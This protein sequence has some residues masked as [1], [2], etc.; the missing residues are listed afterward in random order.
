MTAGDDFKDDIICCLQAPKPPRLESVANLEVLAVLLQDSH[1]LK[2]IT[3]SPKSCKEGQQNRREN[4][5]MVNECST[6]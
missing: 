2:G 3:F 6:N 1:L 5:E 4:W